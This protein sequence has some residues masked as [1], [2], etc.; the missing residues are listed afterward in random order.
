MDITDLAGTELSHYHIE[1]LL[2]AGGMGMVYKARQI[3]LNRPVALKILSPS[4]SS[5]PSFIKR[6]HRE[7]CAVAQLNHQNIVQI[8]DVGENEGI[9]FFSMEWV[10]GQN[11]N[12]IIVREGCLRVKEAIRII[13]GVA[14]AIGHAHRHNIIHR[15]IKPSNI[16]IG[17]MGQVKVTDFGLARTVSEVTKLTESGMLIGTLDYMSPEQCRG[18]TL[19]FRTD[20]Y[21][22]GAVLYELLTRKKPFHAENQVGL[23]H[24]IIYDVP[25]NV[26]SLNPEIPSALSDL[27]A[28]AMAKKKEDRYAS[29]SEFLKSLSLLASPKPK[30]HDLS[31]TDADPRPE[32]ERTLQRLKTA[33]LG[34]TKGDIGAWTGTTAKP[35]T[36]SRLKIMRMLVF[37]IAPACCCLIGVLFLYRATH[38]QSA[39]FLRDLRGLVAH[40]TRHLDQ[41]S[42]PDMVKK[43]YENTRQAM[44]SETSGTRTEEECNET[45]LIWL[46]MRG[47]IDGV[48]AILNEDGANPNMK[49]SFGETALFKAAAKGHTDIVNLLLAKGADVHIKDNNGMTAMMEAAANG[50]AGIVEI[51][52]SRGADTNTKNKYGYTALIYAAKNGH[53]DTLNFLLHKGAD[54]NIQNEAGWTALMVALERIEIVS[55]LLAN[56]ADMDVK[57]DKGETALEKAAKQG[58]A[59]STILLLDSSADTSAIGRA[60]ILA[61][62]YGHTEIAQKLK[63]AGAKE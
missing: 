30:A 23:I 35:T 48:S 17:S 24:K 10:D 55:M 61:E 46:A 31:G 44:F 38:A 25:S 33:E 39:R 58:L 13:T 56:G 36:A 40:S 29:I 43:E 1:S 18:E 5:D 16:M 59:D 57:D 21:A 62:T 19:D 15:D 12:E 34:L 6:F 9:H 14:R 60:L 26:R 52:R 4:L 11:L 63:D 41:G 37:R 50:N 45:G 49:N 2:G 42:L 47:N 8:Y 28:R 22:I 7:A 53:A 54:P 51:L 32:I 3:S 20:I 27:V